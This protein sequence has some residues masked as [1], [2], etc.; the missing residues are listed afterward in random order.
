MEIYRDFI[1][2]VQHS[3]PNFTVLN[4]DDK[5]D[6]THERD[7]PFD[8]FAIR[9]DHSASKQKLG[10]I[11]RVD[12]GLIHQTLAEG[13]K[14]TAKLTFISPLDPD[15]KPVLRSWEALVVAIYAEPISSNGD[16]TPAEENQQ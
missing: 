12:N 2:G 5:L 7:N 15:G 4:I 11:K 1:A 16:V 13:N 8:K 6:L 14:L 3:K 10:Y 9:I